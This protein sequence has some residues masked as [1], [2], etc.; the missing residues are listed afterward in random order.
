MKNREMMMLMLQILKNQYFIMGGVVAQSAYD[1][2]I[3]EDANELISSHAAE[4]R[5]MIEN[6]E[7]AIKTDRPVQL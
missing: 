3:R 7:R 4:T 6:L 2:N 1:K 5:M